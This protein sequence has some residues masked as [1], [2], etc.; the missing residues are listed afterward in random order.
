MRW[1]RSGVN[2]AVDREGNGGDQRNANGVAVIGDSFPNPIR[3]QR[4]AFRRR[5]IRGRAIAR[6]DT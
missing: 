4:M 3:Q 1:A 2:R 6:P 5:H